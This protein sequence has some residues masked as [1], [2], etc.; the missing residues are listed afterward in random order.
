LIDQGGRLRVPNSRWMPPLHGLTC[1]P[2]ALRRLGVGDL[3][4]HGSLAWQ[5][6][7]SSEQSLRALDTQDALAWLRSHGV[8]ARAIDWFWRSAMLALLNVRLEQCSAAAAMRVFRLMLGRSGYHF[9]FPA[10]SLSRLYVPGCTAAI[11]SRGGQVITGAPV[12]SLKLK[13]GA[14]SGLQLR[15]GRILHAPICVLAVAPW[16]AA[17]LLART[18]E[19]LLGPLQNA[20]RVFQGAPYTSTT[21]WFDRPVVDSR[22]WSR[23]WNPDDLNVDFY[24][25]AAIRSDLAGASGSVI[26]CN[27]IGPQARLHWDDR[28]VIA[29]TCAELKEFAPAMGRSSIRHARVHRIRAAIPQPRPGTERLRPSTRTAVSG[30][31]LAGDWIDT[32]EPCSMESAARAAALAAEAVLGGTLAVP[33]P[34]TYGLIAML[35][36]SNAHLNP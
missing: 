34:E 17:R 5:A 12:R 32:A 7:R 25:L 30:L 13:A 3:L 6:A 23:V 21:L 9:G 26:A 33:P 35:R 15:S 36:R 14:V 28:Q 8:S 1:L 27:A 22:F 16:S 11:Q 31:L 29:R 2:S 19:P 24:D 20:A 10:V 18:G 4:S